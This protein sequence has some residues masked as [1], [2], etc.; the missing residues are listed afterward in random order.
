MLSMGTSDA[1]RYAEAVIATIKAERAAKGW[2]L[3]QLA[4]RSGLNYFT[5]RRLLN[6][7]L[8]RDMGTGE[9]ASFAKAF[10]VSPSKLSDL[11]EQRMA[12]T[13]NIPSQDEALDALAAERQRKVADETRN[14]GNHPPKA[15]VRGRNARKAE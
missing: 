10:G 15:P 6:L 1:D 14:V 2:T 12:R 3:Q 8:E 11:A 7:E 4:D 5:V 9:L 13:T